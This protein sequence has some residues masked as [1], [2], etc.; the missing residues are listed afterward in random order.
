VSTLCETLAAKPWGGRER[1][2]EREREVR[3]G[4]SQGE[5]KEEGWIRVHDQGGGSRWGGR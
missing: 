1:E 2:R 3:R 4:L 5:E